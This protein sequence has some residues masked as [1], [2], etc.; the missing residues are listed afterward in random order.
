MY[1]AVIAASHNYSNI[2]A[3]ATLYAPKTEL[4]AK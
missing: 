1:K 4:Q 2:C 3:C